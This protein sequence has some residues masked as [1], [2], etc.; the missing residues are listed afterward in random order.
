[1]KF[2]EKLLFLLLVLSILLSVVLCPAG[3]ASGEENLTSS[4]NDGWA[5]LWSDEFDDEW[6]NTALWCVNQTNRPVNGEQQAYVADTPVEYTVLY[7][8]MTDEEKAAV[9]GNNLPNVLESDGTLKIHAYKLNTTGSMYHNNKVYTS[10]KL[11]TLDQAT[12]L[13]LGDTA[14]Q[15]AR[16]D[17]RVRVPGNDP[18]TPQVNEAYGAWPA[19]W[20]LGASGRTWPKNCEIDIMETM[21]GHKMYTGSVHLNYSPMED[22]YNNYNA[23]FKYYADTVDYSEWHI[24]SLIKEENR[25][26]WLL[27]GTCIAQIVFDGNI[28]WKVTGKTGDRYCLQNLSTGSILAD[29]EV[30]GDADVG[31]YVTSLGQQ[32]SLCYDA[33]IKD[34]EP[35]TVLHV[36]EETATLQSRVDSSVSVTVPAGW[37]GEEIDRDKKVIVEGGKCVNTSWRQDAEYVEV[38]S[39][40]A[41]SA[42]VRGRVTGTE[43]SVP[44]SDLPAGSL[45][46]DILCLNTEDRY[47]TVL[48]QTDG[49][50]AEQSSL[51]SEAVIG[52]LMLPNHVDE[53][54]A[55]VNLINPSGKQYSVWW[56]TLNTENFYLILN[57][58]MGGSMPNVTKAQL[59]ANGATMQT[60]EID[61]VRVYRPLALGCESLVLT[62]EEDT[63]TIQSSVHTATSDWS[64]NS[65]GQLS[66]RLT[67]PTI[68]WTSSDPAVASVDENGTVT[69]HSV[70]TAII[71]ATVHSQTL[72]NGEESDF[73]ACAA[74]V[75]Q[76]TVAVTVKADPDRTQESDRET[77]TLPEAPGTNAGGGCRSRL[78]VTYDGLLCVSVSLICVFLRR[79]KRRNADD[80]RSIKA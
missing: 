70:G 28:L 53:T 10:G 35:Y 2:G 66:V 29:V 23:G 39:I 48:G 49:N 67:T 77:G 59:Q 38:V 51:R 36:G 33:S 37:I 72:H 68:E 64:R 22:G 52:R 69:S 42:V 3:G 76:S 18:S 16:I 74:H 54:N 11:T 20:M 73:Y 46:K 43:Q 55:S 62:G 41:E 8:L 21:N 75:Y 50:G 65:A 78:S 4:E 71:T 44:L 63:C 57:L 32:F 31:D 6:I 19:V 5:L 1:M 61:Y 27:D 17:V 80:R 34:Y 47:S 45:V 14:V 56:N 24:F 40:G 15:S 26:I 58:A 60:M 7:D 25:L 30:A 79:R 9:A 13:I 12:N